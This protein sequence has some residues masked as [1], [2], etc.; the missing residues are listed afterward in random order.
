AEAAMYLVADNDPVDDTLVTL[1]Y[2][3]VDASGVREHIEVLPSAGR[4]AEAD[5]LV[6]VFGQLIRDL[7]NI[8]AHNEAVGDPGNPASLYAHIFVYEATEALAL[9]NA[10]KRH[11]EDPRVRVGLLHMVRLFPPDEVVP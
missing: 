6:S 5:A 9:Q 8:D 2:R 1:G 3:Y 7:E 4:R 10:V 11:L